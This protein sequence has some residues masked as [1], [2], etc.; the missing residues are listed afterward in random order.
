MSK[1]PPAP[2]VRYCSRPVAPPLEPRAGVGTWLPASLHDAL[3]EVARVERQSVSA[4]LRDI[5]RRDP[6]IARVLYLRLR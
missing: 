5:L 6:A 4:T 3:C 1:H 2:A